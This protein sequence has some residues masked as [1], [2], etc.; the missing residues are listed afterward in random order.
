MIR[1][2]LVEAGLGRGDAGVV[3]ERQGDR[4]VERERR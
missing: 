4:L 1:H 2:R 3:L